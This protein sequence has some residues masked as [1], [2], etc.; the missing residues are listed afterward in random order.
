VLDPYFGPID[1]P[2]LSGNVSFVSLTA[3]TANACLKNYH[4]PEEDYDCYRQ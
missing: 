1:P 2:T 4:L 3:E